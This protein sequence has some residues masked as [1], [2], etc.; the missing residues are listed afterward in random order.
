MSEDNDL[1]AQF[2]HVSFTIYDEVLFA[3]RYITR[4]GFE[5]LLLVQEFVYRAIGIFGLY[6]LA[7]GL[8]L[9]RRFALLVAAL[10]SLGATVNGPAV[11][12]VEYEPVPRGF[13]LPF[14]M[15]TRAMRMR[16]GFA[17]PRPS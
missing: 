7:T 6:L 17:K 11:L 10:V 1:V 15:M 4:L 8:G 14:V 16:R 9:A 3:L 2:P 13:A 12:A 5:P